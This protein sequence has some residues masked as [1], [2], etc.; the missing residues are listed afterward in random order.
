[1]SMPFWFN[2]IQQWRETGMGKFGISF[3]FLVGAVATENSIDIN[4]EF[5]EKVFNEII[6]NPVEG[7]YCE[8]RWCGNTRIHTI[9]AIP[10]IKKQLR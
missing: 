5:I 10:S 2:L 1:M 7:Y 8:V 9:S 4:R 6:N 3:P